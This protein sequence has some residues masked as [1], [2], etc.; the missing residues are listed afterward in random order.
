MLKNNINK[1]WTLFLD[2]DGVINKKIDGDYVKNVEEFEFLPNAIDTIVECSKVFGKIIVVT[3]QQGIG[4]GI[5][6]NRDLE[7]VHLHM[8]QKIEEKGG[9]IDAIYCA[10]ELA[11]KNSLLRKPNI[12]MALQAKKDF[13][14]INFNKSIMVGDS[15]SDVEFG[16]NAGMIP[17]LI[18]EK[19]PSL[20]DWFQQL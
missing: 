10:P 11:I 12:G 4:K 9:K 16:K 15:A 20:Y 18:N 7:K 6:T 19:L 2:R 1:E 17:F 5:M 3:N 14:K 13:P 8:K